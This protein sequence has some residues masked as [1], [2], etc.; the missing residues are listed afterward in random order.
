M[1]MEPQSSVAAST[2]EKLIDH[3]KSFIAADSF[4]C[5]GAKLALSRGQ[6]VYRLENDLRCAPAASTVAS[7]QQFSQD[8]DSDSA[9]L[10]SMVV[11]FRHPVMVKEWSFESA[12]WLYLKNMHRVDDIHHYWDPRLSNDPTSVDFSFSIGGRG[13]YVVG[14]NPGVSR[15]AR[16]FSRPALVFNLHDQFER[17]RTDGKYLAIRDAGIKRDTQLEET[18]NPL[19]KPFGANSEASQYNGHTVDHPWSCPFNAR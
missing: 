11:L 7:L 8:Y 1:R 14:L 10:R 16:R 5:I 6:I 17:L 18:P 3:F 4:P 15:A 12:L 2:D 13:Y 9:L 19:L